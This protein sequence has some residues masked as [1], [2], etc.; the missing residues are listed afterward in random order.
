MKTLTNPPETIIAVLTTQPLT[1]LNLI[2]ANYSGHF[3]DIDDVASAA[4]ILSE[5]EVILNE[6][7][8]LKI[9]NVVKVKLN[10]LVRCSRTW[11]RK[12]HWIYPCA[13]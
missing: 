1:N 5:A 3:Q 9:R 6:W 4:D 8:V 2:H 10:L 7:R 12:L 11:W 13:V